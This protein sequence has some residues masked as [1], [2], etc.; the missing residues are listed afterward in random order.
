MRHLLTESRSFPPGLE[1]PRRQVEEVMAMVCQLNKLDHEKLGFIP[2]LDLVDFGHLRDP[3]NS[4]TI[5]TMT[6]KASLVLA[7]VIC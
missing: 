7:T 4:P 3:N 1:H 2:H 5:W 6:C